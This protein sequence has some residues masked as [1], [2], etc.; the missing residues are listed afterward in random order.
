MD[1]KTFFGLFHQCLIL[2][3]KLELMHIVISNLSLL[4]E[5][6]TLFL[7]H[8]TGNSLSIPIFICLDFA[9]EVV[10]MCCIYCLV[11][12]AARR[13]W[14]VCP[15]LWWSETKIFFSTGGKGP[16]KVRTAIFTEGKLCPCN[17]ISIMSYGLFLIC[18]LTFIGILKSCS[19]D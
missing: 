17:F 7:N 11:F 8:T 10:S 13:G 2:C 5:L 19:V 12:V 9:K 14:T 6:Y 16:A 1:C 18:L 15:F 4:Y 3:L